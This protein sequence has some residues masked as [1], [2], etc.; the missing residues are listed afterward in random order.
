AARWWACCPGATRGHLYLFTG[1][2]RF[3]PRLSGR[4]GIR[5][6]A[7]SWRDL[8][9]NVVYTDGVQD[10]G[11]PGPRTASPTGPHV[12]LRAPGV[13][14]HPCRAPHGLPPAQQAHLLQADRPS[15]DR[16][17]TQPRPGVPVPGFL[18][19]AP[20]DAAPPA[21]GLQEFLRRARQVPPAQVP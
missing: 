7:Y 11:L 9:C 1:T 21:H 17:E 5:E 3:S 15:A 8:L 18:G 12:R 6:A 19:P 14:Q 10:P 16:V 2:F 20:A 4:G 13:E